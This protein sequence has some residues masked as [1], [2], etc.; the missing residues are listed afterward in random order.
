MYFSIIII[1]L[2][3]H[4]LMVDKWADL[5]KT[6]LWKVRFSHTWLLSV[7]SGEE[8]LHSGKTFQIEAP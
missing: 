7:V 2:N 1:V 5:L 4:L 8:T 3:I 6:C